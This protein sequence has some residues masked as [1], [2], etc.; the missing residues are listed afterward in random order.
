[1]TQ[2]QPPQV[3]GMPQG[4]LFGT[5][6]TAY[7]PPPWSAAAIA[8]FVLS[9]IGC[10]GITA[11]F[12]LIFGI[13]GTVTA[14]EGRR[15]GRGLAIAAIPISLVTGII[16]VVIAASMIVVA[17]GMAL[18]AQLPTVLDGRA[19]GVET[20]VSTLREAATDGFKD[21][22]SDEALRLWLAQVAAKH[23]RLVEVPT[24]SPV[25]PPSTPGRQRLNLEGKF[26][27]GR[28]NITITFALQGWQFKLDDIEID[29]ASP[30]DT[31]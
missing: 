17:A 25:Q 3:P 27:N 10:T 12:G 14:R 29:G 21:A 19:A 16:S 8:G 20:A 7:Q 24:A 6:P 30:R 28:T 1:M 15:R 9:L 4:D 18:V 13:I 31:G 26:V 2:F 23:G 22:V 11:P 5:P